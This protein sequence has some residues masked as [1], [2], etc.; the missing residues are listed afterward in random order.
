MAALPG[1]GDIQDLCDASLGLHGSNRMLILLD[2]TKLLTSF[3][4][5]G[6]GKPRDEGS[7]SHGKF[8]AANSSSNVKP[9]TAFTNRP[10]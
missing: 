5:Q 9:P 6:E 1:Q 7:F 3:F 10:S 8:G 4:R 2:L